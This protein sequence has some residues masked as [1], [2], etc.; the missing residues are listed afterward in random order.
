MSEDMAWQTGCL[1]QALVCVVFVLLECHAANLP[2]RDG[3]DIDGHQ[4]NSEFR[5]VHD[6]VS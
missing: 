4:D 5:C 3:P 1:V 6:E 2:I